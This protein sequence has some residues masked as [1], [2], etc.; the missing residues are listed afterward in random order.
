MPGAVYGTPPLS[1]QVP[2][3]FGLCPA[4]TD[5][6]RVPTCQSNYRAG[7]GALNDHPLYGPPEFASN[8]VAL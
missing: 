3:R 7:T 1:L 4:G 2:H 8:A 5:P 6:T